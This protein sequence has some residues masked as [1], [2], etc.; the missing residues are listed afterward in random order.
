MDENINITV[1]YNLWLP[2][3]ILPFKSF[4][5]SYNSYNAGISHQLIIIFKDCKEKDIT[6][7]LA[8]L[9]HYSIP[10]KSI[11]FNGGYDIDAYFFAANSFEA[12]Y[13]FFF[14][15]NSVIQTNNWLLK[16]YK[17]IV[18][19]PKIGICSATGSWMSY[20]SAVFTQNSWKYNSEQSLII[21]FRKYKLLFKAL[22]YYPFLFKAF[23]NPHIRTNAFMIKRELLLK[24]NFKPIKTKMQA[25]LFESVRRSISNQIIDLGYE[26]RIVDKN[27]I[28]IA[29]KEWSDT[30]IFWNKT[31]KDL[32]VSDNQ[33]EKYIKATN[34]E[35]NLYTRLAWGRILNFFIQD[36]K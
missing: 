8:L 15:T 26:I 23:P 36:S 12:D 35:K 6:P 17:A 13:L 5:T 18:G 16:M 28:S 2:Y 29:V 27:G 20:R 32:M 31:Q 9:T 24:V 1:F 33:T 4:L 3:D 14:N 22:L 10:F 25:Y 34:D 11:Y 19:K 21:N 7:Y 30:E